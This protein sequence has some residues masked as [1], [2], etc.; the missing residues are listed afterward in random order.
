MRDEFGVEAKVG[1]M[2]FD[3]LANERPELTAGQGFLLIDLGDELGV[4]GDDLRA[5]DPGVVGRHH[6]DPFLTFLADVLAQGKGAL[7]LVRVLELASRVDADHPTLRAFDAVDLVHG[8]FVIGSDDL[9]GA[10]HRLAILTGLKAPLD[11]LGR[12]LVQ[13]VVDMGKGVLLDVGDTNVLVRVHVTDGRDQ[14]TGQHVDERGF[15]RSVWADDSDP[16]AERTLEGD[17][18]DLRLGRARILEG[19]VVDPHDGLGLGL[20]ALQKAGLREFELEL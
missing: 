10:V 7:V 14:L 13:M 2:L 11:V 17:V 5:W 1:A 19:H 12:G 4:R 18:R 20:D 6:G 16:R 3:L 8:L 9:V 15:A